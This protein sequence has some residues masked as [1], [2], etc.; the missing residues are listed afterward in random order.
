MILS[1]NDFKQFFSN[2][3]RP[4]SPFIYPHRPPGT[5][6]TKTILGLVGAFLDDGSRRQQAPSVQSLRGERSL[7]TGTVSRILVCAP[8]NAAIDEIVKRLK[9]GIRNTQGAMI[10]PKVV[11]IGSMETV[12]AEVKDVALEA[13]I[14]KELESKSDATVDHK[15]YHEK[16]AALREKMKQLSIDLDHARLELVQVKEGSD[17]M[18]ISEAQAKIKILNTSKWKLGQELDQARSSFDEVNQKKDQ[19]R[20]DA[21]DKI[22]TEAD[23]ICSTLSASGHD[24]LTS[25]NFTFDTVIIDEA[26]QSVEISSLIPLK[27]GTKRCV[28]VGGK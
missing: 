24:L 12:N 23:V 25:S 11:R 6:K 3:F 7:E 13:L 15:S 5:G 17:M 21:R 2:F 18:V 20:K 4:A 27:Y 14:A 28:L 10:S 8:S 19:A 22:L 26:A 9:G 1:L 16:M